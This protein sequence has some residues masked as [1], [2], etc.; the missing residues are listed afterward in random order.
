[1]INRIYRFLL[2]PLRF[3]SPDKVAAS[4]KEVVLF[5]GQSASVILERIYPYSPAQV[6]LWRISIKGGN[7]PWALIVTLSEVAALKQEIGLRGMALDSEMMEVRQALQEFPASSHVLALSWHYRHRHKRYGN[8][9][10]SPQLIK[11]I[12]VEPVD[13]VNGKFFGHPNERSQF[14]GRLM[15]AYLRFVLRLEPRP[16][17]SIHAQLQRV[18]WLKRLEVITAKLIGYPDHKLQSSEMRKRWK[19]VGYRRPGGG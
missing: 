19:R 1:M 10:R 17:Q 5:R 6:Q 18:P 2:W 11:T 16:N 15:M 14:L 3:P 12:L 4:P 7:E 9:K 8:Q 13:L